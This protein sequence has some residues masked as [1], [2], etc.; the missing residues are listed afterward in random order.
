[1]Q[2]ADFAIGR[3]PDG[4]GEWQLTLPTANATN[5]LASIGSAEAL[6][7][8]EWMANSSTTDDWFEVVNT[9]SAPVSLSGICFTDDLNEPAKSP[10]RPLSFIGS[11]SHAYVQIWAD[12]A[13]AS[14][15][16]H[17]SFKL[18]KSG[19][20][21]AI[22]TVAGNFIDSLHFGSQLANVSEGRLP[23]GFGGI[24][25]FPLPTP[26][27]PNAIGPSDSDGDGLPDAWETANGLNPNDANDAAQ[28]ADGDGLSNRDEYL[29]GT[30][31]R[32]AGSSLALSG[33][34]SNGSFEL[35]FLG[36]SGK[37]YSLQYKNDLRQTEWQTLSTFTAAQTGISIVPDQVQVTRFYRVVVSQ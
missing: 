1:L 36:I 10:I 22:G 29:A 26:G 6:R 27:L 32:N 14:G 2:T 3:V 7:L 4:E 37:Q 24:V 23:D 5:A 21:L 19:S 35:S 31:P 33:R 17:A 12:G 25:Q 16:N 28:D 13:T 11:G 20:D 9:D 8:N 30:D 15:A 34:V 18:S